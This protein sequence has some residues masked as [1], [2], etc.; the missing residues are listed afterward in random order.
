MNNLF[1]SAMISLTV[2]LTG[3]L[4]GF[5]Y[6]K[7]QIRQRET[8]LHMK[9]D[10]ESDWERALVSVT[11]CPNEQFT[12]TEIL[13][14]RRCLSAFKTLAWANS[15]Y[16][17]DSSNKYERRIEDLERLYI[18][19]F[20]TDC[21]NKWIMKKDTES[22]GLQELRRM[23]FYFFLKFKDKS[24]VYLESTQF[25]CSFVRGTL[26]SEECETVRLIARELLENRFMTYE[27][28]RELQKCLG[29][30]RKRLEAHYLNR[31]MVVQI[32]ALSAIP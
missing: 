4:L 12:Q 11:E 19:N 27:C 23:E 24:I 2:S 13:K 25:Q 22:F 8:A 15:V 7:N 20:R 5:W 9:I 30:Q 26:K 32:Q 17:W 6:N 21:K 3:A 16:S 18:N 28:N 14:V 1:S 10:G 31:K 29:L